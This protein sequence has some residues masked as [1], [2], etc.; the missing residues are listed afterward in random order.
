MASEPRGQEVETES[1]LAFEIGKDYGGSESSTGDMEKCIDDVY[2]AFVG[3]PSENIL[4]LGDRSSGLLPKVGGS[5]IAL[6]T[7]QVKR[8]TCY[9]DSGARYVDSL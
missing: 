2:I 5:K 8:P 3:I 9:R 6:S 4:I 1:E 7:E